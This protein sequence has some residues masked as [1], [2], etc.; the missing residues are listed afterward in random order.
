MST[1]SLSSFFA[2]GTDEASLAD[3][4]PAQ[5]FDVNA[6][7]ARAAETVR[8]TYRNIFSC[9]ELEGPEALWE[10]ISLYI[11]RKNLLTA[12]MEAVKRGDPSAYAWELQQALK[13]AFVELMKRGALDRIKI[14]DEYPAE[15]EADMVAIQRSLQPE[16]A[17]EVE[18]ESAAAVAPVVV[19]PIDQCVA[20]WKA[21]GSSAFKS[22]WMTNTKNR[23]TFDQ[24]V[25]QGQL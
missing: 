23:P 22:K 7:T 4:K 12:A 6:V 15:A 8:N 20:D 18:Q 25:A 13:R 19:N 14:V 5:E 10:T 1:F 2:N 21:L 11:R 16:P 9:F 24:A 17:P 3:F